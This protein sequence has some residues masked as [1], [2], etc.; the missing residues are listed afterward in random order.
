MAEQGVTYIGL[1]QPPV[2]SEISDIIPSLISEEKQ[3]LVRFCPADAT[4]GESLEKALED[5][6]GCRCDHN[7]FL[8]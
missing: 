5:V 7:L 4:N 1:D 6:K 2:I 8:L 3:N